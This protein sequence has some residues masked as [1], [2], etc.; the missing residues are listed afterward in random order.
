MLLIAQGSLCEALTLGPGL[1][2]LAALQELQIE[3]RVSPLPADLWACQHLTRLELNLKQSA[4]LP[5]APAA[6]GDSTSSGTTSCLLPA[7]RMLRLSRCRLPGGALPPMLCDLTGLQSLQV[8]RCGLT[9]GCV[10][11]GMPPQFS[12]LSNLTSLSLEG[13]TLCTLPPGVAM[14][15]ALRHLDCACN[16]LAW[17]PPGPYLGSLETLILSA[18]R[19]TVVPPVLSQA[20]QLEVLAS[21]ATQACSCPCKTCIP[22]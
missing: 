18:N 4:P 7:L 19:V 8:L 1:P 17:L 16:P 15:P 2:G 6:L 11:T 5:P 12:C 22:P 10:H 13:N 20:C 21:A 9:S 14:L 3:S